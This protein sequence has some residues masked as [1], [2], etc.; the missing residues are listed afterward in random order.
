MQDVN[1]L[2]CGY[3]GGGNCGDEAICDRLIEAIRKSGDTVT[4]LSLSP[5]ESEALHGVP[6]CGR[7]SPAL[8]K[9][10]GAC[11]LFVLGG[12][13]LLQTQTSCRSAICYLSLAALAAAMGK[14]WVLMGG[15]DPVKGGVQTIA[16]VILPT[17]RAFFLRDAGS[18]RR[19]AE[20]APAVPRFFLPDCALLPFEQAAL[21]REKP[22]FPYIMI[23]PKAGVSGKRV[24][25]I[26]L[27]AKKRGVRTVFLAMSR[28]DEAIC[29]ALSAQVGG[30]WI[31]VLSPRR[32]APRRVQAK[33]ILPDLPPRSSH[34][35]FAALPCEIACRLIAGAE[36]VYSAR[37]HGLIFAKKAG[38]PAQ[39]LP[40][41]TK[42]W[43]FENY[44]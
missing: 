12:G 15:L 44:D 36:Q 35:Y 13:T 17:A 22:R 11:D 2:I 40:D 14:P 4:L 7:C 21:C 10:M 1:I 9:A 30:V 16:K 41:G 38:I 43:K 27:A 3:I 24:A 25:G 33:V 6:A 31:G 19:A 23:C 18:L 8:L 29:A 39:L 26:A 5:A 28:E 34:R 20:L 37:L 32:P 42:Q